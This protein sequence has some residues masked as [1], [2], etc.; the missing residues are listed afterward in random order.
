MDNINN[1]LTSLENLNKT[2]EI[3]VPSLNKKAKF[4]GLTTKQQKDAVKSALDKSLA[5]LSFSNLANSIISENC[6]EKLNFLLT[7]RS[8]IL[9]VLRSL[10]LS[11]TITTDEGTV[12]ISFVE[13]NN[14]STP[15]ELLTF[16]IT[17]DNLR[18]ICSI[19]SL[20]K[21]TFVN[22]ETKKKIQPLPENDNLPKEAVGEMFVNELVKYIDKIVINDGNQPVEVVFNDITFAQR[23]QI[24][25]KLPLTVN[26][27]LVN[28]INEV[29]QFE[30]KYF[31]NNNKEVDIDVDPSLFTV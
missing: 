27:K 9:V 11:K 31:I 2:Y 3:F 23:V 30:R 19:P 1:V 13:T 10:S 28:Y 24:A 18:V 22:N 15:K 14:I 16:E 5:G 17:E 6:T 7:D 25:E 12:D 26:S 8:Y 20:S 21:D 4:K 29:K